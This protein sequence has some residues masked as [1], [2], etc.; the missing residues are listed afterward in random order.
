MKPTILFVSFLLAIAPAFSQN[1]IESAARELSD[2]ESRWLLSSLNNDR[3]WLVDLL[4]GKLRVRPFG[5]NAGTR[6]EQ[7]AGLPDPSL[8]PD[9]F[10]VRISGTIETI[11]SD[12]DKNRKFEFLDT[13]NRVNGKWQM[14]ATHFA[15]STVSPSGPNV[16]EITR[17]LLDLENA[18]AEVDVTKDRSIFDKIIAP[19]FVETSS[20]GTVDR[21]RWLA[22]R[23]YG[24][25]KSARN[26]ETKVNV[27]SNDLAI[28][29]GVDETVKHEGGREIRHRDRFT[30][31]WLRRGGRWQ[32][33]A[34]HVT[35]F[36]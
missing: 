2:F 7:M 32:C 15:P 3:D 4:T 1:K 5:A 28:V 35:R 27:I 24:N 13:F 23:Q 6:A 34:A 17:Q 11:T 29:T 31:T 19:E 25:V 12:P 10:K 18:W 16:E 36:V 8:D 21:A 30:D 20:R 14:I 22:E 26:A 9:K 33:V